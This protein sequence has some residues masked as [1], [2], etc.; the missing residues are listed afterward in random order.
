M[1]EHP[2]GDAHHHV[3]DLVL[4]ETACPGELSP[5]VD[6]D[7]GGEPGS[8]DPH[9]QF[10][11]VAG[12]K[13]H[14]HNVVHRRN[15]DRVLLQQDRVVLA[16]AS[17]FPTRALNASCIKKVR[18]SLPEVSTGRSDSTTCLA[19]TPYFRS[20]LPTAWARSSACRRRGIGTPGS[21][22][23]SKRSTMKACWSSTRRMFA[24]GAPMPAAR[25]S[26]SAATS[27]SST[28][29][30][31]GRP[32]L[33]IWVDGR[34]HWTSTNRRRPTRWRT[35]LVFRRGEA[36]RQIARCPGVGIVFDAPDPVGHVAVDRRVEFGG[37]RNGFGAFRDQ[38]EATGDVAAGLLQ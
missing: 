2:C 8:T 15:A 27:A 19:V 3:G 17:A 38:D 36:G 29:R 32:G 16:W 7:L 25:A 10:L 13:S 28:H 30:R 12:I 1:F 34:R 20:G 5:V 18:T 4:I 33:T 26:L 11:V 37:G 23:R 22:M 24:A 31:S 6:R 35:C 14:R 21:R 9:R